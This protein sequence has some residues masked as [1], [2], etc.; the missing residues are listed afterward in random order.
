MLCTA[1]APALTPHEREAFAARLTA[2][3]LEVFGQLAAGRDRR[4]IARGLGLSPHT[5]RTHIQKIF[6]KLDVHSVIEALA[7]LRAVGQPG[8][9]GTRSA[10]V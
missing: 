10:P 7:L 4:G 2:R 8:Q 5:V 9:P 3:E 6:V 1:G